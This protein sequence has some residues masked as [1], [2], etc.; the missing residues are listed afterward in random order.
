MN[1][2]KVKSAARWL[3]FSTGVAVATYGVYVGASWL[4]Y[5]HAK[6]PGADKDGDELLDRFMPEYEIAEQHQVKVAAPAD[7]TFS[8]ACAMDLQDSETIRAIFKARELLLCAKP[9]GAD[10][11]RGLLAQTEALGWV[12][13]AEIPGREIVMGAITEPW[14]GTPVFKGVPPDQFAAFHEP[15]H[16]KIA[17]TLRADSAGPNKSVF[18]TETRA[19]CTDAESRT[20]FRLYWSFLSAGII[21]IRKMSLGPLKKAAEYRA[22]KRQFERTAALAH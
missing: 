12:V 19:I 21:L 3:G 11:P 14:R 15:G 7:I 4:R 1:T 6:H 8:T 18:R 5:G 10:L 20:K 13:L 22:R 17:W 16:V 2:E 9:R